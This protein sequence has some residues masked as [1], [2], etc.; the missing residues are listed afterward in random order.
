MFIGARFTIGFGL[1]F[2]QNAP[3]LLLIELSYPTQVGDKSL[4]LLEPSDLSCRSSV[5]ELS[6]C[7][8]LVGT[9][10][11]LFQHGYVSVHSIMPVAVSGRGACQRSFRLSVPLCKSLASGS[12]Q[13]LRD[14]PSPREWNLRQR[15]SGIYHAHG[16]TNTIPW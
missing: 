5:V 4:I 16:S 14:G 11:V 2:C 6:R 7:L 3:P 9:A 12:C 10:V 15:L 8:T 1:S 13:S